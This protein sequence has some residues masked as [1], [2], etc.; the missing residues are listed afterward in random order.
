MLKMGYLASTSC[1][2]CVSH[3][4]DVIDTYLEA[5]DSVF[6]L[7]AECEAGRSLTPLGRS[8][9]SYGFKRLN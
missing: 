5:L 7:I 8:R 9:L 1:Y 6:A 4:S 3:S 2:V